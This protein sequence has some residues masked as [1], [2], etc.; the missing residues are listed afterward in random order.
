MKPNGNFGRSLSTRCST[1]FS[2]R[3]ARRVVFVVRPCPVYEVDRMAQCG[4]E[5]PPPARHQT[6]DGEAQP[7][8]HPSG[9][10]H[11]AAIGGRKAIPHLLLRADRQR[12][13]RIRLF[14]NQERR[15][16]ESYRRYLEA[17]VIEEFDSTDVR[18]S[19]SW[20]ARS[21]ASPRASPPPTRGTTIDGRNGPPARCGRG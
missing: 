11:T 15:L 10:P 17:G 18:C 13:F 21:R 6:A 2:S 9:G 19:S 8:A 5:A 16:T 7:D 4:R 14:C 12:P 1:G 3:P 20:S